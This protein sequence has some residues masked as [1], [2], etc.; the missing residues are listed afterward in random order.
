MLTACASNNS[1]PNGPG[2]SDAGPA[3]TGQ[4]GQDGGLIAPDGGAFDD[5]GPDAETPDGNP[6]P[7]G[8]FVDPGEVSALSDEFDDAASLASWSILNVVEGT[9]SLYT[10]LDIASGRA[11]IVPIQS[12]WFGDG[13]GPF[14]YKHVTG[15]FVMQAHVTARNTSNAQNPPSRQYNSAGLLVRDP[16]SVS[17]SENWLMYNVG[18]QETFVGTEGK[19]TVDST[20]QLFLT[21]GAKSGRLVICRLGSAFSMWRRL[22]GENTWQETDHFDRPDLPARLQVGIIANGYEGPP[23]ITAEFE[24]IRFEVPNSVNDCT[25]DL[26]A[27]N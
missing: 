15:N 20:S 18:F 26:Q 5:G 8:G 25:T 6:T 21:P 3:D 17:G 12:G 2:G 7:D 24:Y 9:A 22:D 13:K 10:R 1:D 16:A 19:T 11:T 27:R 4:P 14:V 23:D